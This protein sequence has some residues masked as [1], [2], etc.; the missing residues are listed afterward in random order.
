M[1]ETQ[2]KYATPNTSFEFTF[3]P[4]KVKNQETNVGSYLSGR[5]CTDKNK[6]NFG[7]VQYTTLRNYLF[8]PVITESQ[9]L[10]TS[11]KVKFYDEKQSKYSRLTFGNLLSLGYE[12]DSNIGHWDPKKSVDFKDF[13]DWYSKFRPFEPITDWEPFKG[14]EKRVWIVMRQKGTNNII[15][16]LVNKIQENY[17]Q[18]LPTVDNKEDGNVRGFGYTQIARAL[19]HLV[20]QS[21]LEE[22]R[23]DALLKEMQNFDKSKRLAEAIKILELI[24]DEKNINDIV[25]EI[26][27]ALGINS[28]TLKGELNKFNKYCIDHQNSVDSMATG[29]KGVNFHK[30]AELKS[31]SFIGAMDQAL[32]RMML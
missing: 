1:S 8:D 3:D 25:P 18:N 15:P 21:N 13:K 32:E 24:L 31:L 16:V 2:A 29:G 9:K 5:N 14:L 12:I 4:N 11:G 20:K 30:R 28:D 27:N 7:F 26:A 10:P 17:S 19:K 22:G 6:S 23:K